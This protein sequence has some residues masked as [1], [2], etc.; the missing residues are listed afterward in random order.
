MVRAT[1][2]LALFPPRAPPLRGRA[3]VCPRPRHRSSGGRGDAAVL[4]GAG[5]RLAREKGGAPLAAPP[6]LGASRPP[7]LPRRGPSPAGRDGGRGRGVARAR[8]RGRRRA[9][10]PSP[11]PGG[12]ARGR[13]AGGARLSSLSHA[14]ARVSPSQ[15]REESGSQRRGREE[16]M[17]YYLESNFSGLENLSRV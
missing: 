17:M 11:F 7:P 2:P 10:T 5:R 1:A 9:A 14:S 8:V 4:R 3:A 12:D 16:M 15:G 6:G 13:G